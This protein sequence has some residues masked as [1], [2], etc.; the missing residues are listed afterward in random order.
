MALTS[1]SVPNRFIKRLLLF[2]FRGTTVPLYILVFSAL[3]YA[4]STFGTVLGS[5][6][7]PSA[8]VVAAA[9]IQLTNTGTSV[10]R[11]TQTDQSGNYQ[12]V[13]IDVGTYTITVEAPGFQ[14]AQS[15]QFD[16]TA[17]ETKRV[18][19]NLRLGSQA[20]TV[21]VQANVALV[22][23]DSS[24]I[25]ESK[26]TRELTDL[27]VAIG[28]RAA[29]STSAFSTL[30]A[31]PGVQTDG[32]FLMVAGALPDQVS[33]TLDG[34][35]N[36]KLG[37]TP[38]T[39]LFPSF[40]SIEEIKISETINPAS[41]GGAADITTI[42]RSGTNNFHGGLFENLQN[43]DFN[44]ADT[45]SHQVTPV[46]MNDF[47]IYLGGPV[48]FPG[49]NGRNKTF[50]F[51]TFEA[52]RLPKSAQIVWSVPTQAMRNGDLTAYDGTTVA[53]NLINPFSQKLLNFFYPLPN[54]GPPGAIA[55][56]LLSLYP[57]PI[58]S[59]QGDIRIDEII[60]PKH[61]VFARYT[62][63]NKREI[64]APPDPTTGGIAR[65]GI[66][67]SF[68]AAYN[69]LISPSLINE[70]RTGANRNRITIT[71]PISTVQAAAE[72]GITSPPL[73]SAI[74][75]GCE[76]PTLS[77]SGYGSFYGGYCGD[78]NP[79][80]NTFQITEALTWTKGK[81][82]MRFG[83]SFYDLR[84]L[85]TA[86]YGCCRLGNYTFNGS[87]NLGLSPF[88]GFLQGFPDNTQVVSVLPNGGDLDGHSKHWTLYAQ[89][90]WKVSRSLTINFGL[91]WE[92]N[93]GY[94]DSDHNFANWDPNYTSVVNGQT[95]HGAVILPDQASF[96]H[97]NPLTVQTLAG[98]PFLLASQVGLPSTLSNNSLKDFAPRIGFAYRLGGSD[99]TVL[100]GGYGR[101]I[102][103][104]QSA[105]AGYGWGTDTSDYGV[106][107]NS[108]GSNGM[109]VY[110]M[111]YSFPSNIA[112][113]GTDS[114]AQAAALNYKDPI[115]EEWNLTLER[116][117]GKGIAVRASY[118][119]N[120][121]YNLPVE[122]DTDQVHPNTL[123][124]TNPATQAAQ[125][126]P[127]LAYILSG[128]NQA[129]GNY[130][131]GTIS[132]H[133]RSSSLQFEGSY[134]FTRNLS[135]AVG[136]GGIPGSLG[137]TSAFPT[138]YGN[139][140]SDNFH[141]GIDYGNIPFNRRHRFLLTALYELPFGKGRT[142]L[143]NNPVLDRI[144]GGW[145]L[146]VVLLF[147]TGPFMSITTLNDP[148][149]VGFNVFNGI[150]G[151]AD[152]VP[153]MN[154]YQGQS[155]NQWINPTAFVD[156]AN[157]IGRFGDSLSGGVVGPGTQAVSASLLK[158]FALT[159]RMRLQVGAQVANL[160]NHPNYAPPPNLTLDVPGFGAITSMQTAEGASPRA[161]QLTGRFTF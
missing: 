91:R 32:T 2:S 47:G 94:N 119:G 111:P 160:F 26:G 88:S 72:L 125:P 13:N 132:V 85:Y 159:E 3:G 56:N 161:I 120:H 73:P 156:P 39:E 37:R 114:F 150:G 51:G 66:Y 81:H 142:F 90:D 74:S 141:P 126:F 152:T 41:I 24:N 116:D 106:F 16:L 117:L 42:T 36:V 22:Q 151:R 62:Y 20:S 14:R 122:V 157:N 19:M 50:F 146:G 101:F 95:I 135:N 53:P 30:T 33:L 76:F 93:P 75:P 104:L 102:Q 87:A 97:V 148:S 113:P 18:D 38:T 98:T 27:P 54:Y 9:K 83:G 12:F 10:V 121:S 131:A 61:L 71:Q 65:P 133:K 70:L 108:L 49:Y 28:T 45:F 92:Y 107:T 144:V 143:N 79:Q 46:Q 31:Q 115:V 35:S 43:T 7:D 58:N 155:I 89:D 154:P 134:T 5:V 78:Q 29:G 147:Q 25:A 145:S 109:P 110:S 64:D 86:V 69:W 48:I 67:N 130:N 60:T 44:A 112:L 55:N 100:R 105:R 136:S 68:M 118:D 149:G 84:S 96:A 34:V 77:I 158:S 137:G 17:R 127:Q 11:E 138:E 1:A 99:K 40:Y 140:I 15:Q 59:A 153:G 21:D 23:T 123:G 124:F 52:L 4:Q 128:T 80:Q 8:A 57:T 63:K 82:T 139:L 103:A 6:A 129:F